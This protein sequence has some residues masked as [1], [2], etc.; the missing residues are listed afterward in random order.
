MDWITVAAAFLIAILSGMGVGSA[1]LLVVYLT[2]V[3][4]V[5]QLMA[6]GINLLFFL[7]AASAA[8]CVH[9]LRRHIPLARVIWAT[10]AGMLGALPGVWAAEILP[11]NWIRILFGM[12]LIFAG[13]RA[14]FTKSDKMGK[15][16]KKSR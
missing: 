14:F 13:I 4:D 16:P 10:L 1:G 9:I 3:L 8:L 6:Q 5:P 12:M 7:F 2:M 15:T 11:Q